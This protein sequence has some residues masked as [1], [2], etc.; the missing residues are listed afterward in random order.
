MA[1]AILFYKGTMVRQRGIA[2]PKKATLDRWL[3]HLRK[4]F[5]KDLEE[6]GAPGVLNIWKHV[7]TQ[8]EIRISCHGEVAFLVDRTVDALCR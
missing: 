7:V 4:A 3:H 5:S 8:D 2:A 1:Q 6:V